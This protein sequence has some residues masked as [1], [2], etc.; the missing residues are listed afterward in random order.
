MKT[1]VNRSTKDLRG[2]ERPLKSS[3]HIEI[4]TTF[5]LVAARFLFEPSNETLLSAFCDARRLVIVSDNSA[6]DRMTSLD[7]YVRTWLNRGHF[8]NYFS[9]NADR[10][11][12]MGELDVCKIVLAAGIRGH[13]GRH[14]TFVAIG[15]ERLNRLVSI[16]STSFRR[17]TRA[18]RI[19]CDLPSLVATMRDGTGAALNE[20]SIATRQRD[21][22]V[23]VDEDSI[24]SSRILDEDE[25]A[26][27]LSLSL[28]D[29]CILARLSALA[30]LANPE[31]VV[32]EIRGEALRATLDLC[33]RLGPDHEAWRIG[34]I[35]Q[36]SWLGPAA[37]DRACALIL[38]AEDAARLGLFSA[39]ALKQVKHLASWL[40]PDPKGALHAA[41]HAVDAHWFHDQAALHR[42]DAA[43]PIGGEG[44]TAE[45]V[46]KDV[47]AVALAHRRETCTVAPACRVPPCLDAQPRSLVRFRIETFLSHV[48]TV[49]FITGLL[50]PEQG[51]IGRFLPH[52]ARIL[53]VVD[54]YAAEI[55][56]GVKRYLDSYRQDG[57]ISQYAILPMSLCSQEK[58]LDHV[59]PIIRAAENL[60][61]TDS[62][63][64]LAVGGGTIMDITGYAAFMYSGDTPYIRLP[65]TLVGMIDAGIGLKVGV[66]MADHKN[67]VGAYH[68]PIACLSD[69]CFL[70]TLPVAELRCGAAEAYKMGIIRDAYLFELLEKEHTKLLEGADT[71]DMRE[72]IVRAVSAMLYELESNPFEF[73]LRRLP[74]FGHEFGHMLES[75]SRYALRHG[76]AVAIGMALSCQLAVYTGYLSPAELKR[77]LNAFIS[78]GLPVWHPVCD[79]G[80]LWNGLRDDV[81]PHKAGK[82]HLVV[83]TTI[84]AGDFIDVLDDI[85]LTMLDHACDELR[86]HALKNC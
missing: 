65:T 78:I 22:Q 79:P 56:R 59:I 21:T 61:L 83:P 82:L 53:A 17:Y 32:E 42:L 15:G 51:T 54:A 48:F 29:P 73:D 23:L 19:H 2:L 37:Q 66:N 30:H 74:D 67:L 7:A 1:M 50:D 70:R 81:V 57:R 24:C 45:I 76:E 39:E 60:G 46:S 9:I 16:A 12:G 20:E 85:S 68:P 18:V 11:E 86:T 44:Q 80:K 49:E 41:I 10:Y 36:P 35:R 40:Y 84:G 4:P 33:R 43:P 62:D 38:V 58:T 52:G 63:R 47:L 8:D 28:L 71:A 69:T 26:L 75:L 31:T 34:A 5:H 72:I 6:S 14:D 13:L 64:I 77:I 25:R 3:L 55:V 27:L